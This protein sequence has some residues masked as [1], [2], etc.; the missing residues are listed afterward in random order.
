MTRSHAKSNTSGAHFTYHERHQT[1][2]GS[3]TQRIGADSM[4]KLDACYLCLGKAKNAVA[5]SR[6]HIYCK[7]CILSSLLSQK[8]LIKSHQESLRAFAVT[9]ELEREQAKQDARSRVLKD[10]E[11]G[12]GLGRPGSGSAW[13]NT[14]GKKDIP[15]TNSTE[16][17]DRG[18]KRKFEFDQDAVERLAKEAEDAALATI[19]KEQVE[20][21]RSKLPSFWLP[22]LAPEAKLGPLKDV[23]LQT[24]CNVG[25]HPHPL[26]MKGLLPVILTYPG[27]KSEAASNSDVKPICPSCS[28]ELTNATR[29]VLLSS[30]TT[31]PSSGEAET[32]PVKKKQKKDKEGGKEVFTCGHVVCGTC[33][34]T[35]VKPGK[36]CLICDAAIRSEKDMID[37]GKEGTGFAAAGGAEV[38]K[39][40]VAFN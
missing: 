20:A 6:G 30:T 31:L 19:E 25:E 18:V 36:Q 39:L 27:D 35:V 29:C 23:K 13:N 15:E 38:R 21:R 9:E 2:Y 12:L 8:T 16:E 37:L 32:A 26:A 1:P 28:R 40:G 33:A 4:K 3:R 11:K 10:F 7:E 17:S 5:C 14:V 24:L 22:T 34:D